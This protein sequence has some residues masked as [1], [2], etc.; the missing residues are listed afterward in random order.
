MHDDPLFDQFPEEMTRLDVDLTVRGQNKA[1]RG[2]NGETGGQPCYRANFG[3]DSPCPGCGVREVIDFRRMGRWH[4]ATERSGRTGYFEVTVAPILDEQGEVVELVEV[5]RNATVELALQQQLIANSEELEADVESKGEELADLTRRTETL[6]EALRDLRR[7]Q[8]ALVHT[9]KMASVGRL[10]AGLTHEIHTPL[11]ALMSNLDLL[12]RSVAR[13]AE[14]DDAESRRRQQETCKQLLSLQQL[15]ADRIQSV[16]RSLRM[17]AHLDRAKQE[18]YELREGIDAAVE[19]LRH[20]TRDGIEVVRRYGELPPVLC[21]PDAMNQVFMTLLQNAVD[22]IEGPGRIEIIT[23][24]EGDDAV[25]E[26][27]DTG[28]GIERE[29]LGRLFEPGFTTKGRGVGTGLGLAIAHGTIAEHHGS[30][31]VDST[32]GEGTTF[33]LRIPIGGPA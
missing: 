23:R 20:R 31:G 27:R 4:V 26:F 22:A 13:L 32:P 33:T 16:A 24:R 3:R 15:A 19:L 25:L 6:R 21:R 11:G 8:A 2:E 12:E 30:I 29:H 17:F 5:V 1:S 28:R 7:D 14:S 10:A 9:E 18:H